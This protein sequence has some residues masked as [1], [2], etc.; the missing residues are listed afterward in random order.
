M[1]ITFLQENLNQALTHLAKAIP[2]KP[3]L[4]ILSSI[5]ISAGEKEV[6]LSATDLYFGVRTSLPI[7]AIEPGEVVVPGKQFKEVVSTLPAGEMKLEYK[8]GV[9]HIKSGSIK[10]SLQCLVGDDYP[11]FPQDEG[12]EY[13]LA[14]SDLELIDQTVVFSASLDQARPVLTSLLFDFSENNLKV[15][16]TDGFRLATLMTAGDKSMG[17]RKFL[18]PAKVFSEVYRIA[19]QVGVKNVAIKVSDELKQAFITAGNVKMFVRLI[20]GDYPPY[21]KII[22]S[23]FGTEVVFDSGELAENLK[24]AMVFAR[25]ASNIVRFSIEKNQVKLEAT[26][27]TIGSFLGQLELVQVKGDQAEIAFNAKYILDYLQAVKTEK[28]WFG[29]NESLKPALFKTDSLEVHQYVTM[30]FKVNG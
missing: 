12:E 18:L 19:H 3:Q 21:E 15:V 2:S 29:M 4:P 26:S 22:P 5:L 27:P 28:V 17:E 10:A 8:D 20:D 7:T 14:T 25:D 24:R 1:K 30:P 23:S 13:S 6:T 9:L 16:A 11:P